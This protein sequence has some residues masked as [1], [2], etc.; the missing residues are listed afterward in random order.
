MKKINDAGSDV[1]WIKEEAATAA[2]VK[3][4]CFSLTTMMYYLNDTVYSIK[5]FM[6]KLFGSVRFAYVNDLLLPTFS[7]SLSCCGFPIFL[8]RLSAFRSGKT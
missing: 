2:F 8:S 7:L 1:N 5:V 6:K 4:K 3:H